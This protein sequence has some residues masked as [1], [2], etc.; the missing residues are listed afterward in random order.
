M[1]EITAY[2]GESLSY[3]INA[4]DVVGTHTIT[5]GNIY[6]IKYVAENAVGLSLDSSLLF[7]ALARK[8]NTPSPVTFN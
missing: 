8:P 4:G 5:I 1:R 7:V 6:T 2:D 3:T